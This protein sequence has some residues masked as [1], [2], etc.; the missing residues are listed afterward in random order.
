MQVVMPKARL[1]LKSVHIGEEGVAL[2]RLTCLY[3]ALT[4]QNCHFRQI[5][6]PL[7]SLLSKTQIY[8]RGP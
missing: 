1:V 4:D 3:L 8:K 2:C 6:E 7:L 5:A